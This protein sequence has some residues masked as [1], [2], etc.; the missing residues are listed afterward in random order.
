MYQHYEDDHDETPWWR[1][2]WAVIAAVGVVAALVAAVALVAW[3]TGDEGKG[4]EDPPAAASSKCGLADGD[5]AIPAGGPSNVDWVIVDGLAAP[6]SA[7]LGPGESSNNVQECFAR[8]AAGAVLAASN[9]YADGNASSVD[10]AQLI[11]QRVAPGP[12]HDA[13]LA[14]AESGE[15]G[16]PVATEI[17]GFR[18]DSY[19]PKQATVSIAVRATE[20]QYAGQLVAGRVELVWRDGDWLVVLAPDGQPQTSMLSSLADYVEWKAPGGDAAEGVG[21]V[22]PGWA[23]ASGIGSRA[24]AAGACSAAQFL[25]DAVTAVPGAAVGTVTGAASD[26]AS[27]ATSAVTLGILDD[28]AQQASEAADWA[29]KTLLTT[30]MDLPDPDVIGADSVAVWLTTQM[31]WLIAAAMIGSILLAA[32]RLAITGKF[33]HGRELVDALVRVTIVSGI[34]GVATTV[35]MEAGDLFSEWI[36][37]QVD[38]DLNL[39]EVMGALNL[40]WVVLSFG[41]FVL[42]VQLIQLALMFV[43]SAMVPLLVFGITL[44]AAT[45]NTGIGRQAFQ[46]QL[47][48]LIAFVLFKP[49][50]AL[51]YAVAIK[52]ISTTDDVATV[53]GGM[54]LMILGVLALPGLMRL[55]VPAT[56]SMGGASAGGIAGA[57]VGAAM[58]TGAVVATGG[59]A[60]AGGFAGAGTAGG[61]GF[62]GAGSA[63]GSGAAMTASAGGASPIAGAAPAAA[64]GG[65]SPAAAGGGAATAGAG[66]GSSA[67]ATAAGFDGARQVGAE[68]PGGSGSGASGV[69][70]SRVLDA[71][72][73]ATRAGGGGAAS[74]VTGDLDGDEER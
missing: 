49:V 1:R 51:I 35:A 64:G 26:V 12:G 59:A 27:E 58:A 57:A 46:K 62:A 68:S 9:F 65:A 70:T 71:A 31:E 38:L 13:A 56:A 19:E 11:E 47:S 74:G 14:L 15:E 40:A 54:M 50:A 36:F 21:R 34:V 29:L 63:G 30:W 17:V 72:S 4:E 2:G 42:I 23:L 66:E 73:Q 53:L 37:K 22:A 41:L 7:E 60:A 6:R 20:G 10:Q 61:A 45:S 55:I 39:V 18:V 67:G 3:P 5:Q 43:R 48:W 28:L 69:D 32:Y 25:C 16:L 8:S 44:S 24:P 52:M 33:E